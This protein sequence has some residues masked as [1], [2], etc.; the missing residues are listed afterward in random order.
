MK[1]V[2]WW[3]SVGFGRV[4]VRNKNGWGGGAMEPRRTSSSC[5]GLYPR[6]NDARGRGQEKGRRR[7]E[8]SSFGTVW[9]GLVGFGRVWWGAGRNV[10]VGV[11]QLV[12]R[13]VTG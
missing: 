6:L 12:M 5:L 9:Y 11:R 4:F 10:G 2:V 13:P 1:G 7:G 8:G 3:S